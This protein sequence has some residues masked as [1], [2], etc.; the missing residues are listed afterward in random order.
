MR[1]IGLVLPGLGKGAQPLERGSPVTLISSEPGRQYRRNGIR[2]NAVKL[3]STLT[4]RVDEA[5]GP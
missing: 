5:G 4:G 2:L 1:W 3:L